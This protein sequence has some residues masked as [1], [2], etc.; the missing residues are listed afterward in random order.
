MSARAICTFGDAPGIIH[1]QAS[2]SRSRLA[3]QIVAPN[4]GGVRAAAIGNDTIAD[5]AREV[6]SRVPRLRF[7]LCQRQDSVCIGLTCSFEFIGQ[8]LT[9]GGCLGCPVTP[10][11]LG[12]GSPRVRQVR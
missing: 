3:R 12:T 9:R 5:E 7:G 1:R 10:E 4:T 8:C 6:S 2:G 11:Q